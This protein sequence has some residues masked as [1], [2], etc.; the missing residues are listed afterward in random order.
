MDQGGI[1]LRNEANGGRVVCY[2]YSYGSTTAFDHPILNS[3]QRTQSNNSFYSEDNVSFG[4]NFDNLNIYQGERHPNYP[5]GSHRSMSRSLSASSY[6]FSNMPSP[7][8]T[9]DPDDAS[10]QNGLERRKQ[11]KKSVRFSNPLYQEYTT[12]TYFETPEHPIFYPTGASYRLFHPE[13]LPCP[14]VYALPRSDAATKHLRNCMLLSGE[15]G[16]TIKRGLVASTR[17]T[18]CEL[19]PNEL[20]IL[21]EK[22][23]MK[24]EEQIALS[25]V[26]IEVLSPLAI[27]LRVG[28]AQ[29]EIVRLSVREGQEAVLEEWYW[30]LLIAMG[31]KVDI[32]EPPM[33]ARSKKETK[34]RSIWVVRAPEPDEPGYLKRITGIIK[35]SLSGVEIQVLHSGEEESRL[36]AKSI[37]TVVN[38]KP[39]RES[40]LLGRSVFD[41]DQFH[42]RQ[43]RRK[44]AYD[45]FIARGRIKRLL[46]VV[47]EELLHTLI[48]RALRY[49]ANE[50]TLGMGYTPAMLQICN[51]VEFAV[52]MKSE[53]LLIESQ[54]TNDDM[55]AACLSIGVGTFCDPPS[56]PGLA[57]YVEHML[58]MGSSK[59]PHEN[60]FESYLSR[61]GGYSNA[62]TDC[63]LT[64]YL[65]EIHPNGF[66][67]ALDMFANFFINPLFLK[68]TMD[69]ELLAI[70]AEFQSAC[71]N[72]RVRL[73][74]VLC[75]VGQKNGND[76]PY[77]AFGWGNLESLRH[78]PLCES[79]DVRA[80]AIGF[81][82]EHYSSNLMKLA[83]CSGIPL[84]TMELWINNSFSAIPNQNLPH[85]K[86]SPLPPPFNTSKFIA[87]EPISE[88]HLIHLFFT[89]TPTSSGQE[90][91]QQIAAAEYI[92]YVLRHEGRKSLLKYL[93]KKGWATAIEAG[94]AE[95]QGY[96]HGTY[97]SVFEVQIELTLQGVAH[98]DI[99]VGY[100]Y[101]IMQYL[102]NNNLPK[103]IHDEFQAT[104]KLAFEFQKPKDAIVQAQELATYMQYRFDI[105]RAE[106]LWLSN[107][108]LKQPFSSSSILKLVDML[109]PHNMQL[110][111]LTESDFSREDASSYTEPWCNVQY[112]TS[113]LKKSEMI[114]WREGIR[115]K[116][117]MPNPNPYISNDFTMEVDLIDPAPI[118]IDLP[119]SNWL[120]RDYTAP[121]VYSFFQIILP[122][123]Q[124]S[125]DA[126]V[127]LL[128][129]LGLANQSLQE[130]KYYAQCAEMEIDLS[131]FDGNIHFVITSY[132]NKLPEL[133]K[134]LFLTITNP[135]ELIPSELELSH[136]CECIINEITND[137]NEISAKATYLRLQLLEKS[138]STEAIVH[139]LKNLKLPDFISAITSS[140]FLNRSCLTSFFSGNINL[141]TATDIVKEVQSMLL[142]PPKGILCTSPRGFCPNCEHTLHATTLPLT[143]GRGHLLRAPSHHIDDTNSYVEI[144]YQLGSTNFLDHAYA[145]ILRQLMQE[146]LYY[147]LRT[148]DQVGYHV[149]C[150]VK[151]THHLLGFTIG[152][153]SSAYNSS[154]I[155]IR[156]DEFIHQKFKGFID[157]LTEDM[158]T[159]ISLS[160][161]TIWERQVTPRGYWSEIISGRLEFYRHSKFLKALEEV[162]LLGVKERYQRWFLQPSTSRKLRVHIVGQSHQVVNVPFEQIADE[163]LAP[164][165]IQDL[166]AFRNNLHD[167][168]ARHSQIEQFRVIP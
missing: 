126:H 20:L 75:D 32:S 72:D 52:D 82:R 77:Y 19:Y 153:E 92:R 37:N 125:V 159:T 42:S 158:I 78:R 43:A 85:R 163:N 15:L 62:T 48:A 39:L 101:S 9:L 136:I 56:L 1:A 149:N 40:I 112:K 116:N 5:R 151:E 47:E 97:G 55:A 57:H 38:G 134:E 139:T 127:C 64:K 25:G 90:R 34:T 99:I 156:I 59:Y 29:K 122:F 160:R 45:I 91:Q 162:N 111:M 60:A 145:N 67:K 89:I 7:I 18:V 165:V 117:Y 119:G 83:V 133:V 4:R 103:W 68:S 16:V 35:N 100:I 150:H 69:R 129:Y 51:G 8:M 95:C 76:H 166:N 98:W 147:Q 121:I 79:I 58:F 88:I 61:Y 17:F 31:M 70:E 146:P 118:Q 94:I 44:L 86:F 80:A 128:V 120:H 108:C 6:Q 33:S 107:S 13:E 141:K 102:R 50:P 63:E 135:I 137:L 74:Q 104:A 81:Y 26:T 93:Y 167:C 71:L 2:T 109:T 164:F 28:H 41:H 115:Q 142:A 110:V 138:Y 154:A 49:H 96:E 23:K 65:F 30:M 3:M 130:T 46:L 10:E 22:T 143:N 105:D 123:S 144:Y 36:L 113:P 27:S 106:L 14:I 66:E 168:C 124:Q 152:V 24:T 148:I 21:K 132:R 131:V 54:N 12:E 114:K 140:K 11:K 157:L 161:K 87:F 84:D 73:Q 155:A 53:V